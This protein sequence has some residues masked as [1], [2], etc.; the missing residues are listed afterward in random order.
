MSFSNKCPLSKR[1]R[2]LNRKN[3]THQVSHLFP[4]PSHDESLFFISNI[5]LHS[6]P[7]SPEASTAAA[8][9]PEL[10]LESRVFPV[11]TKTNGFPRLIQ[12]VKITFG[13]KTLTLTNMTTNLKPSAMT[14]EYYSQVIS[15]LSPANTITEYRIGDEELNKAEENPEEKN[16]E[17]PTDDNNEEE[18]QN[19]NRKLFTVKKKITKGK[20]N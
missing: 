2:V 16:K 3:C 9:E 5:N 8:S 1:R 10:K 13:K 19:S 15:T 14:D 11:L 6:D 20:E 18:A 4:F 17:A 7:A 12:E